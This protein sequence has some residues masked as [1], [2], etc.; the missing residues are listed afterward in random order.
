MEENL[1]YNVPEEDE[2]ID[3]MALVKQLWDGKKTIIIFTAVF[4]V[5]GLV[6]ALTMKHQ[7]TVNTVMVPQLSSR[8]N[9]SLLS[10]ASLAGFDIG[11][12]SG[13]G[14][15]LS[16]LVYPQIVGS[17]P[18]RLELLHTPLHYAKADTAVSMYTY[19]KEYSKPTVMGT[20][21]KYTLGLP[22]V[23]IGA[24]KKE[25][26]EGTN[27]RAFPNQPFPAVITERA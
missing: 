14:G 15:D 18:Y 27:L 17:V 25:K 4:M 8:S 22:G 23:I 2:G 6:S 10:I 13:S 19:A 21:R 1:N 11:M 7:Y 5:L 3:I 26:P 9:S 24:F 16:P 20:I 12:S